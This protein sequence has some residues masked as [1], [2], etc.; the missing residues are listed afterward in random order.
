MSPLNSLLNISN[1]FYSFIYSPSSNHNMWRTL[2]QIFPIRGTSLKANSWIKASF[3]QV[4]PYVSVF[5]CS[6]QA[7]ASHNPDGESGG[8]PSVCDTPQRAVCV[9]PADVWIQQG[10]RGCIICACWFQSEDVPSGV[11]RTDYSISKG[12]L[13]IGP[14]R[15]EEKTWFDIRAV[16][17]HIVTAALNMHDLCGG[18]ASGRACYFQW[19]SMKGIF[20]A[21]K[22]IKNVITNNECI[23]FYFYLW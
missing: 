22:H 9:I 5:E 13:K 4:C 19:R 16:F 8:H 17:H 3:F 15:P 1:R 18:L 23:I 14:C 20:R 12:T 6:H 10:D 7:R 2:Q 11:S 21:D